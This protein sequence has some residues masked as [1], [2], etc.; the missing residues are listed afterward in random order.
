MRVRAWVWGAMAGLLVAA[1]HASAQIPMSGEARARE[2]RAIR[3]AGLRESQGDRIAAELLLLDFLREEPTSAGALFALERIWTPVGRLGELLAPIERG[4]AADP[5]NSAVR[6]LKLR[7]LVE[8]DS[9]AAVEGEI[10]RWIQGAPGSPDPFLEG[11]R[12]LER[13]RGARAAVALLDR[14]RREVGGGAEF[15]L[16]AGDFLLRAGDARAAAQRWVRALD[17]DPALLPTLLRRVQALGPAREGAVRPLL[18]Q[19]SAPPPDRVRFQAAVSLALEARLPEEAQRLA[20]LGATRLSGED[21]FTFLNQLA[22]EAAEINAGALALWALLELR[23]A[24]SGT[25]ARYLD[26]EI[27]RVALQVGDTTTALVARY[28]EADAHPRGSQERLRALAGPIR[29]EAGR[30]DPREVL[31]RMT[32][33]RE[34]FPEARELD[35]AA[36]LLARRLLA[37]GDSIAARELLSALDGPAA[38]RQRAMLVLGSSDPREAREDLLSAAAGLPPAEATGLLELVILLDGLGPDARRLAARAAQSELEGD[39]AA[40]AEALEGAIPGIGV[41]ER[42]PLLALAARLADLGG[43][44]EQGVRLRERLIRDHSESPEAAPALLALAYTQG[45]SRGGEARAIQ[46]LE[47]LIL[48]HPL[49]PV[50]PEA[51]RELIRLMQRGGAPDMEER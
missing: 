11:A 15:E 49:S 24:A 26:S 21:R 35:E 32:A 38:A 44:P 14:G 7:V 23:P 46:L 37:L 36:G 28:R 22:R 33:F 17:E 27:A 10:E 51:R 13:A 16:D 43:E 2:A 20:S 4:I 25:E 47:Q 40:G 5:A 41:A 50:V 6:F 48:T 19:L 39:P 8:V 12:M 18:E 30:A 42:A 31:P 34:E 45:R 9:L 3:E 29:V 1:G